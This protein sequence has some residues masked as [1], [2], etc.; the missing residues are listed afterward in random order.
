MAI[1]ALSVWSNEEKANHL[2]ECFVNCLTK[3][4][5]NDN[6]VLKTRWKKMQKIITNKF[7]KI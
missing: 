3:Y 5:E 1:N 4:I 7:D 6:L 2:I